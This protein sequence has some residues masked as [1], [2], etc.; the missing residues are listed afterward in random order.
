M[1]RPK[2]TRTICLDPNIKCFI[3]VWTKDDIETV[4]IFCDELEAMKIANL[5]WLNMKEGGKKMWVSAPTFNRIV[6]LAHKKVTDAII[7]GKALA[8]KKCE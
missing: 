1:S 7:N 5:E 3:P 4:E 8:I 2:K 6:S